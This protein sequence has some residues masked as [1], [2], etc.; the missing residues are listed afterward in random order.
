M[1]YCHYNIKINII[2]FVKIVL[3]IKLKIIGKFF[4]FDIIYSLVNH[5][6][7]CERVNEKTN[8]A[9][10]TYIVARLLYS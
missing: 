6:S 4:Y 1:C 9:V 10:R 3:R 8:H 7:V 5:S 2:L